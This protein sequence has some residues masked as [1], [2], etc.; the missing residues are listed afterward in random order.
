MLDIVRRDYPDVPA[1]FCDTGLEFPEI[2]DF[3]KTFD[4]VTWL[5][6]KMS[7]KAVIEKYG[8]PVP[9]KK[10]ATMI[11]RL[12]TYPATQ[13]NENTRRLYMT[14]INSKGKKIS[15]FKIAERW[16]PLLD[17]PFKVSGTC[18]D[19]MKKEPSASYAKKTGR[20]GITGEM[21]TDSQMRRSVYLQQGCNAF[22]AKNP[23]SMPLAF[24]SD[25]DIWKYIRSNDVD[26][27]KIYDMGYSRTGCA[28]CAF[29]AHL[30]K[31]ENR[32]QKMKRTHPNLHKY[33]MNKLGMREVLEYC[34]IPVE[35]TKEGN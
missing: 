12:R 18:C 1:V 26:Y 16:K 19:V 5:K 13:S 32:F 10:Q 27:S 7:F 33:C 35:D 34:G 17:A 8:F 9:S 6:P 22:E 21:A 3:V 11:E 25:S 15:G 28:F 20:R 31:K 30:E 29:G 14:G 23:K 2:R 24:W 4:N